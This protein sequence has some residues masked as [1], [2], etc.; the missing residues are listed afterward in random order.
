MSCRD[1]RGFDEALIAARDRL[2]TAPQRLVIVDAA[3]DDGERA[4][5]FLERWSE[6]TEQVRRTLLLRRAADGAEVEVVAT[7]SSHGYGVPTSLAIES[8]RQREGHILRSGVHLK[9]DIEREL[10]RYEPF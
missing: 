4:R 5:H 7:L 2:A 10:A 9:V 3:M 6:D 8:V 1:V